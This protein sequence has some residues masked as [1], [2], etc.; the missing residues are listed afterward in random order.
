MQ[1][2]GSC[3]GDVIPFLFYSTI[4]NLTLFTKEILHWFSLL[5]TMVFPLVKENFLTV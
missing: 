3:F 4:L 2:K 5:I 1:G